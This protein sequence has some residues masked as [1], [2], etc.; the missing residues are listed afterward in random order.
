MHSSEPSLHWSSARGCTLKVLCWRSVGVLYSILCL[1][2]LPDHAESRARCGS[3]LVAHLEFVCGDRGFYR[4]P[5]G[6]RSTRGNGPR[7]RGNGTRMRGKG[8]V[9]QCC[10]KA[11]DLQHLESYCAKPK[12]SRRH[13][14]L[15]PQ[16][17]MEEQFQTVF[18]RRIMN[19]WKLESS[20]DEERQT[21]SVHHQNKVHYG[22]RRPQRVSAEGNTAKTPDKDS[23]RLKKSLQSSSSSNTTIVIF[24]LFESS[25]SRN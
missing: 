3:E 24:D 9:E 10:L 22:H 2:A 5:N 7:L 8:I 15:T 25:I 13:A 23:L 4:A 21:H 16:Q 1:A 11:C 18:R 12:R 14:P 6:L 20:H 19:H 17:V